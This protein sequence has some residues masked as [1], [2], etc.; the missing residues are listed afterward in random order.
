[1]GAPLG[2][3]N[4]RKAKRWRDA[5]D[6]A[7]ARRGKG[8]ATKELDRLA[9]IFIGAIE[10]MTIA[11]EKRGPSIAG[12]V[13]FADR[14]DGKVVQQTEISGPDGGPVETKNTLNVGFVPG[15]SGDDS[16]N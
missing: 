7:L 8:D 13:E 11:T 16:G 1:M 14:L 12:F 2:N 6:R 10:E 9:E 4:A 3:Q 15:R 5:I